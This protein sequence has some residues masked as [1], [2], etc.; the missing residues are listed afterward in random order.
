MDDLGLDPGVE[1][2]ELE[3]RILRQ[4]PSLAAGPDDRPAQ[5]RGIGFA[6]VL[7]RA[8]RG[9]RGDIPFVGRTRELARLDAALDGAGADGARL[10]VLRG[11]QGI[12]KSRLAAEFGGR[13]LALGA[14]VL[15][16]RCDE[17]VGAPYQPFVAALRELADRAPLDTL[18]ARLGDD[19]GALA[20][21]APELAR[22]LP[23]G[24]RPSSGIDPAAQRLRLFDA[25][26]GWLR[27]VAGIGPTV[28]VLEDVHWATTSTAML[29]RHVVRALADRPVLVLAT[30][31][32]TAPDASALVTGLVADLHRDG[33]V[34]VVDL[35]GLDADAIG[36]FVAAERGTVNGSAP[37]VDRLRVAT[38]G[39][40]FL[41][42][43]LARY[44]ALE[45]GDV[46]PSI[47]D[48]L[49]ARI[50][51][52]PAA[53]RDAVRVGAVAGIEFD[54][55]A[56]AAALARDDDDTITSLDDAVAAGLLHE[57]DGARGRYAFV[58]G[59]V[60]V[61]VADA[62]SAARRAAVH[63]AVARALEDRDGPADEIAHHWRRAGPD[64]ARRA[65]E[66][67][68]RVG[69]QA[70]QQLAYDDAAHHLATALA[71]APRGDPAWRSTALLDLATARAG[72]GDAAAGRAALLEAA[73]LA[74][75][76][77]DAVT[78]ARAALGSSVGGRG[79]SGWI[80]DRARIGLLAEARVA[81]PAG[82]RILRIRVTGELAL[83]SYRREDRPRRRELGREAV[84]LADAE[85][86]QEALVA[87]LPA[88]RVA[89]WHP[90]DAQVRRARARAGLRAAEAVGDLPAVVDALDWLAADACELGDRAAFDDAVARGRALA[91]EAGGVVPRWRARVWDAVVAALAGDLDDAEAQAAAALAVWD[92]EPAP[93][94]LLAFGAQ[95][96]MLRLLQGRAAEVADMADRAAATGPSN[97]GVLGP[98]ALVMAAA[99]RTHDAAPLVA[100][101]AAGGLDRLPHDSQWLLGAVTLAEAA[102]LVGDGDA[103][104]ACATALA[105]F[106]DRLATLAGPG[107]VWGSVAHQ[108][109]CVALAL[110]RRAEAVGYLERA[111]EVERAFGAVPWSAR[112]EARLAAARRPA[113]APAYG[114][115]GAVGA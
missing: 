88:S 62:Q 2:A 79:V 95:L 68:V 105:P 38:A 67:S 82:Q 59:I 70:L 11:E 109:G 96:C 115:A 76:T 46:P 47:R 17:G 104:A 98:R 107:L 1:L 55:G 9:R 90:R 86:T 87:A 27:A 52:L 6:T 85:G 54:V 14:N 45:G 78:L 44:G 39:N 72:T 110:G 112:S 102:V 19:A 74:R 71:I 84:A 64:H 37:H 36:A 42:T 93:D 3:G 108:L 29:T 22:H 16:G 26:A 89:Y 48:V 61:A 77:G 24:R 113:I 100:R 18:A 50:E 30:A 35:A 97:A 41:L 15:Y 12:G 7:P 20:A 91:A 114:P 10:V 5:L 81:L 106:P 101:L 53:V 58:H 56:V 60:Q 34:E 73:S 99:G 49:V 80:A 75:A 94:A 13:A 21:L 69:R 4:D 43:A 57:V 63:A 66:W 103:M 51:R 28:V 83:A 111:C 65:A 31:R 92:A 33:S 40:P 25:V 23:A 32:S 8:L